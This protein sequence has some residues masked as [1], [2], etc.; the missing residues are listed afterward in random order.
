LDGIAASPGPVIFHDFTAITDSKDHIDGV[1]LAD[2][3]MN[4]PLARLAP[5][6][7][8]QRRASGAD[9]SRL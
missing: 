7:R 8:K 6:G 9:V 4:M 5:A 1:G 2:E 3:N